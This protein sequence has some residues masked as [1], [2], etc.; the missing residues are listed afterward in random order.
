MRPFSDQIINNNSRLRIFNASTTDLHEFVWHQDLNDRW[1]RVVGGEGWKFQ[2]DNELPFDINK[3]DIFH[4][5]KMVYHRIIPGNTSLRI[6]IDE[7]VE[8]DLQLAAI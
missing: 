4:V 5:P 1:I 6:K 3:D 2:F 7:M 8:T